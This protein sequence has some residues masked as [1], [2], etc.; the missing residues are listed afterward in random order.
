MSVKFGKLDYVKS[1]SYIYINV[2]YIPTNI[3]LFF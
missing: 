3:S 2:I 1:T